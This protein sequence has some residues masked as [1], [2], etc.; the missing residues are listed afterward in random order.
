MA[1][2]DKLGSRVRKYREGL[3]LTQEQLAANTGLS[4]KFIRDVEEG[5]VYPPLGSIIKLSRALGQR[6]GTFMDDQYVKDP[7]I[8]KH[9]ARSEETSSHRGAEGHYRYFPLGKGKTDRHMEPL[10]I[11]IGVDEVKE[12]SSH[13]G[14]EFIIVVS[15]KVL[16][17]YGKEDHI[18][19]K[20]D[21]AYYNSVVPH[22]IGAVDG[23]AEIFAV[24]YAPD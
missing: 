4:A 21:T 24:L 19:S 2:T 3:V 5:K 17:R 20:G 8:V 14:E 1:N 16:V 9:D 10:F 6:V 18:L 15:G 7:V 13:E 22:F 23:P 12:L 11:K